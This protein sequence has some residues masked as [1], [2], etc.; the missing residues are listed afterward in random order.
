M[1][2]IK[3]IRILGCKQQKT[4]MINLSRKIIHW[5]NIRQLT[6]IIKRLENQ[7]WK[8]V[9]TKGS[10]MTK[11]IAKFQPQEDLEVHVHSDASENWISDSADL[12]LSFQVKSLVGMSN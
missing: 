6:E 12:H 2:L 9:E 5:K 11:I 7:I 4:I 3:P 1:K 8:T 10:Q